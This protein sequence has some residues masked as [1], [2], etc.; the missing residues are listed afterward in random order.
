MTLKDR[1]WGWVFSHAPPNPHATLL[2]LLEDEH[3][4]QQEVEWLE[5][6]RQDLQAQLAAIN[7]R[8]GLALTDFRCV[9]IGECFGCW[10]GKIDGMP[11]V[12]VDNGTA[13]PLVV[14]AISKLHPLGKYGVYTNVPKSELSRPVTQWV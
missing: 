13:G 4:R 5:K 8:P 1:F 12:M 2:G 14:K 6:C 10:E 11:H 3:T 9:T 7:G